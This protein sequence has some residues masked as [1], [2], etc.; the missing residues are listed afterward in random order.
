M[1]LSLNSRSQIH[2]LLNIILTNK[3]F[4]HIILVLLKLFSVIIFKEKV[5]IVRHNNCGCVRTKCN[6]IAHDV[7]KCPEISNMG[8]VKPKKRYLEP[9]LVARIYNQPII[10]EIPFSSMSMTFEDNVNVSNVCTHVPPICEEN[11]GC[12]DDFNGRF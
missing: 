12:N 5:K 4:H 8:C 6:N 3:Y 11:C 2:N 1:K 10:E 7:E 9:V